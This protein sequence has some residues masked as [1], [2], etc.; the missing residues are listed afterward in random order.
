MLLFAETSKN[1]IPSSSASCCPLSVET[2]RFSS[3]SHLLP[4][5]ILLTPSVACCSTF[6]NHVRMSRSHQLTSAGAK[7]TSS[8]TVERAFIGHVV[9][10]QYPHSSSV[11]CRRDRPEPLLTRGIPYLQLYSLPVQLDGSDL[12]VDAYSGDEGWGKGVFAEPKQTT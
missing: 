4:I 6:E 8:P 5:K 2:A 11:V 9:H 3:Q 1:G 7:G 10:Q 12:E